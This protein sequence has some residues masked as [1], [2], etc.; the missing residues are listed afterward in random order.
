MVFG[1][2]RSD[3]EAVSDLSRDGSRIAKSGQQLR[4]NLPTDEDRGGRFSKSILTPDELQG[5]NWSSASDRPSLEE[6]SKIGCSDRDPRDNE[7]RNNPS[8]AWQLHRPSLNIP[9]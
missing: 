2:C 6:L 8:G 9:H 5:A 3:K 7:Y 1:K 4:L